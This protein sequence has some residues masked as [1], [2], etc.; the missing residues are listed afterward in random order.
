MHKKK[1]QNINVFERFVEGRRMGIRKVE[2]T[3]E[4]E[5]E[6]LSE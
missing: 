3:E 4:R 1:T 5:L 6:T 2:G